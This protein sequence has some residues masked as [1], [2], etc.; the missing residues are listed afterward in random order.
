M[1]PVYSPA[2]QTMH[3]GPKERPVNGALAERALPGS[4]TFLEMM[5]MRGLETE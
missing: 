4:Y 2:S 3:E 5:I 1:G